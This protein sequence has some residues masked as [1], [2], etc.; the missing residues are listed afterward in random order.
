[1]IVE[2]RRAFLLG[3]AIL[4]LSG[5]GYRSLPPQS[6]R[7]A[8]RLVNRLFEAGERHGLDE[9]SPGYRRDYLRD[10]PA[11]EILEQNHASIRRECVA[12]LGIKDRL[13]DV[14]ALG[15]SYTAGG[16]HA[17]RWKSFV[18]KSGTFIE[19]NCSLCPKTASLLRGIPGV[20]TAFFSILDP[21]QYVSPHWGYYKGFLRY[22]LGVVIPND[23]EGST[24]FLRVNDDVEDNA[25]HDTSLIEGGLK[26]YWREGEGVLFDDTFLH[27]AVNDSDEVR[28]VLWLDVVRR[29]PRP[30]DLVNRAALWIAF[31]DPSVTQ[32]RRNAVVSAVPAPRTARAV[33]E[34]RRS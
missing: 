13:T 3:S 26:Y 10:Y 2:R 28:I 5:R 14:E 16:I 32:V 21:H 11:L 31:R 29:M 8:A 1:V 23:N 22:H 17:I 15:G 30:F 4:Y 27:D 20:Y 7:A 6:K 33:A 9:R 24:C 34:A 12:L 18:F 19:E 25:Q